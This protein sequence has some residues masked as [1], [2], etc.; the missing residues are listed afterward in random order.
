MPLLLDTH[1]LLWWAYGDERL[2]SRARHAIQNNHVY[3]SAASAFEIAIKF[4]LGKMPHAASVAAD[5]RAYV[6]SQHF[7]CLA[8]EFA[9]AER[10]GTLAGPARDP[11]DRLIVAQSIIEDLELVSNEKPFDAY[12][13]RRLW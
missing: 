13:I 11:F 10:A 3:V 4:A 9:H 12:P 8:I 2:S 7:R 5:I 1:A 6:E